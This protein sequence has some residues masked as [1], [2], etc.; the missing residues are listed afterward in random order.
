MAGI[1][2]FGTQFSVYGSNSRIAGENLVILNSE[3]FKIEKLPKYFYIFL[4]LQLLAGGLIFTLG[5]IE[6]L[7]LVVTGAVLNAVSMFVYTGMIL[8]LNKTALARQ[9]RPSIYRT[10]AVFLAFLFYGSF[11]IFTIYRIFFS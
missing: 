4:W 8:Y 11:S 9:M 6:P 2:L 5:F 3:K 7:S 1:M 10:I